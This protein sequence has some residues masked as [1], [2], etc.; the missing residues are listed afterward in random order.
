M[1]GQETEYFKTTKG[2]I[3][4]CILSPSLFLF[5]IEKIVNEALEQFDGGIQI[6][7]R[8]LTNL[9]FADDIVLIDKSISML[10]NLTVEVQQQKQQVW[11]ENQ[12]ENRNNDL[13]PKRRTQQ[14]KVEI[15]PS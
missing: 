1:N 12:Q 9:K 6:G 4:G 10:Q 7:Q 11:D 13:L 3:Q 14:L 2:C 5:Y 8:K 15:R